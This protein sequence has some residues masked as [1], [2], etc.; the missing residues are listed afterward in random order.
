MSKFLVTVTRVDEYEV[1]VDETIWTNEELKDW[2]KTF[3]DVQNTEDFARLLAIT[4]MRTENSHFKEGY[5]YIKE[6]D[7]N[8]KVKGIPFKNEN[9]E[10]DYPM[11]E[12]NY[13]KGL[14]I[15]P[16]SQDDNYEVES[17]LI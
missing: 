5:G 4:W 16:I 3:H 13:T 17:E 8:G 1:E 11:P 7:E 6:L 15:K 14:T 12:E 10:L 2:S 9:G